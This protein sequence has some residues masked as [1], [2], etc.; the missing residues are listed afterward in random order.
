MTEPA[1]LFQLLFN[2]SDKLIAVVDL[3]G[4]ILYTNAPWRAFA[5]DR[6]RSDNPEYAGVSYFEA[7]NMLEVPDDAGIMENLQ[8]VIEGTTASYLCAAPYYAKNA[9]RWFCIR[10]DRAKSEGSPCTVIIH[11]DVTEGVSAAQE[12]SRYKE[13]Y[14]K[15]ESRYRLLDE[16]VTDMISIHQPDGTYIFASK[17]SFPLLGFSPDELA[18]NSAYDYFHP[19]DL[20]TIRK[21]H[22]TIATTTDIFSVAYR[23]RRK[24]GGYRWVET[25]S[26][27]IRDP[28]TGTVKEI[29]A[30]TRDI[31]E[32]KKAEAELEKYRHRLED[33][34]LSR[35]EEQNKTADKLEKSEARLFAFFENIPLQMFIKDSEY[36]YVVVNREFLQ[37]TGFPQE[38][39]RGKTDSELFDKETAETFHRTDAQVLSEG[40]AFHMEETV[41]IGN[42]KY[43]FLTVKFPLL[44]PKTEQWTICGI[45]TDI[46]DRKAA[47][48]ALMTAKETAET[49][50]R[51]KTE[52]LANISHELRTPLNPI[53]GTVD[54]LLELEPTEEQVEFINDIKNAAKRMLS[55]VND[56]ILLSDLEKGE[57]LASEEPF[58]IRS[59]I[60]HTGAFLEEKRRDKE[61]SIEIRSDQEIPEIVVGDQELVRKILEKLGENAVKFT[62]SGRVSIYI[63]RLESGE[64]SGLL[65]FT[66]T[67]TGIGIPTGK[68]DKLF[69]KFTQADGSVKRRYQGLGLGLTIARRMVELLGGTIEAE[70]EEKK[71]TTVR[72]FVPFKYFSYTE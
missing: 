21:S 8:S 53:L 27:T 28:E 11:E 23:I 58:S 69:T 10:A 37:T 59:V 6:G 32:R 15:I 31:E 36:R 56:L 35:T 55:T 24:D 34:V 47:E 40:K 68:I 16:N 13:S 18:G 41:R 42:K 52:F 50:N 62:E 26:K 61:I 72:F 49:A 22:D 57:R 70:S 25:T 17:S 19:D 5:A 33:L 12:L 1:D 29:I 45:A 54:L 38:S 51:I 20:E 30:V 64:A 71:G 7:R 63:D 4:V 46:T 48:R 67:D 66:V 9:K 2:S 43:N 60:E 65:R 3:N 14:E 39:I 44:D